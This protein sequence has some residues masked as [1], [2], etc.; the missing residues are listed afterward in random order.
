MVHLM[1]SP[2]WKLLQLALYY[3]HVVVS[4]LE[5]IGPKP[6]R[7]P[8]ASS[9]E[10]WHD[11]GTKLTLWQ[12]VRRGVLPQVHGEFD[13]HV[14]ELFG[15]RARTW[16]EAFRRAGFV[17]YGRLSLPLY[18]GYGFGLERLRRLGEACGLSAHNAS[19][20]LIPTRRRRSGRGRAS[21]RRDRAG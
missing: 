20:W 11:G 18:S 7:L 19:S 2:T 17:V 15:F 4:G 3:P 1:P 10:L 14:R 16:A 5:A 9:T 13:G 6:K 21:V 12:E 8:E